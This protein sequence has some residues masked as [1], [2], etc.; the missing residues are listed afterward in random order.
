MINKAMIFPVVIGITAAH[1]KE[2]PAH[3]L[4]NVFMI[5]GDAT[6]RD[7]QVGVSQIMGIECASQSE[8]VGAR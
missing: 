3:R 7:E 8:H 5:G 2:H 4:E 1:V 6:R